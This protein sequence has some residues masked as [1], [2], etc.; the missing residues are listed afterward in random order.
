MNILN[1]NPCPVGDAPTCKF[2]DQQKRNIRTGHNLYLHCT[3]GGSKPLK[4]TWLHDGKVLHD[5]NEPDLE[6]IQVKPD[7]AGKYECRVENDFDKDSSTIKIK[8]GEFI[9]KFHR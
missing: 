2:D 9:A 4:Y 3:A 7:D 8:V 5:K 1:A 6:I